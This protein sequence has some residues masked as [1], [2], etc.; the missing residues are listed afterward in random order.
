MSLACKEASRHPQQSS[1]SLRHAWQILPCLRVFT[2]CSELLPSS[3]LTVKEVQPH[4]VNDELHPGGS[5]FGSGHAR[6]SRFY[7]IAFTYPLPSFVA[8]N[9]WSLLGTHPNTEEL[10]RGALDTLNSRLY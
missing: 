3:F 5:Q 8:M 1:I 4:P 9:Y 2:P 7:S 10:F 6:P